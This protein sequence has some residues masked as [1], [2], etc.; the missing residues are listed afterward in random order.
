MF[1]YRKML[2]SAL[3]IE[4][5]LSANGVEYRFLATQGAGELRVNECL[6]LSKAPLW[7][8]GNSEVERI[9]RM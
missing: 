4:V 7:V 8:L 1:F 3:I 9:K 6:T 5:S 2:L